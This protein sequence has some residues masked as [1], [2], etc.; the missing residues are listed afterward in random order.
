M[1]IYWV[2]FYLPKNQGE[3]RLTVDAFSNEEATRLAIKKAH[4]MSKE[5]CH[6]KTDCVR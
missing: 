5:W 3:M 4:K 6:G 2:F 1:A